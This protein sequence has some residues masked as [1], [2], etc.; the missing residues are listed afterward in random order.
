MLACIMHLQKH[1]GK[2]ESFDLP[3]KIFTEC[4]IRLLAFNINKFW[5]RMC[6]LI[7]ICRDQVMLNLQFYLK[8]SL[9]MTLYCWINSK[10]VAIVLKTQLQIWLLNL[11]YSPFHI[12]QKVVFFFL[13]F[14]F[15]AN[16]LHG[17]NTFANFCAWI[18]AKLFDVTTYARLFFYS[19]P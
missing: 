17:R 18:K 8:N 13:F 3:I 2:E 12:F 10:L 5:H 1:I 7:V 15:L 6:I 16:A 9:K 19:I 4:G 11:L 14:F